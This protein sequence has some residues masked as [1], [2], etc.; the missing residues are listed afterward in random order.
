MLLQSLFFCHSPIIRLV[1][2]VFEYLDTGLSDK[3]L[4]EL[5]L[6][7]QNLTLSVKVPHLQSQENTSVQ[8][9]SASPPSH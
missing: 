7:E 6:T 8:S 1:E 9:A 4:F 2:A 3:M 5:V